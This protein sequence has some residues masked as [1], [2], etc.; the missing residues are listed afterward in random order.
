MTT[1]LHHL[2]INFTFTS[3]TGYRIYLHHCIRE[4][5]WN[6]L[7][8]ICSYNMN[9]SYIAIPMLTPFTFAHYSLQPFT[10]NY[11]A[12][13]EE[14]FDSYVVII[15]S[16]RHRKNILEDKVEFRHFIRPFVL[17]HLWTFSSTNANLIYKGYNCF[18]FWTFH[19]IFLMIFDI[20]MFI[21]SIQTLWAV[22]QIS[23]IYNDTACLNLLPIK[24][25]TYLH[26]FDIMNNTCLVCSSAGL[27]E[28]V[29]PW[30]KLTP[31]Y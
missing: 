10:G 31:H 15:L 11:T 19:A 5:L 20:F 26:H 21:Q 7:S 2:S 4:W 3:H 24:I 14:V 12:L 30:A 16:H 18:Y 6:V 27:S 1:L 25:E 9:F 22:P 17:S 23:T 29:S 28:C 8:I 13:V